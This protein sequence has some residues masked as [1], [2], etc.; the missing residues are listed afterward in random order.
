MKAMR[1]HEYGEAAVIREDDVA[2]PIPAADEVLVRVAATSF[3]PSEIELRS[4]LLR[5]VLPLR[6]P[7]TL[8]WDVSGTVVEVGPA[9]SGLAVGDSVV[10]RVDSGAA[11]EFVTADAGVLVAAPRTVPLA[12]AA[13]LPVAGLTAWQAV[14]EH[15]AITAGQ[16]VLINGAGGGVGGFAVQLAKRAGARVVAAEDLSA[17]VDVV[18]HL[19]PIPSEPFLARVRPGGVLVSITHPAQP[20]PRSSVTAKHFVARNDP[21]QLAALVRLVDEGI[22]HLAISATR[23]M[24]DLAEVHRDAEAGR[25]RGKIILTP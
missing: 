22:V 12:Q 11:A 7:A 3:N 18:L 4:G 24:S 13:A 6:L 9:A 5:E 2:W 16:R 8:G 20:D 19:A 25:L 15:A 10:G 23:P 17:P 14:F 21:Q 1:F